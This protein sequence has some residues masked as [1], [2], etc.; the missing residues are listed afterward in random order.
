M[1]V[2]SDAGHPIGD[3]LLKAVADRLRRCVREIDTLARLGGDEF[4]IVQTSLEQ[5][6]DAAALATRVREAI[7]APYV[8]DG[9]KVEVDVSIG[10][11]IAPNDGTERDHPE[12]FDDLLYL[13]HWRRA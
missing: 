7:K 6:S 12:A 3:E 4:A 5:P 10:I 11:A 9:H 2:Q 8:L 13:R 1:R